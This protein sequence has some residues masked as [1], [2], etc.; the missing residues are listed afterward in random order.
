MAVDDVLELEVVVV[1]VVDFVAVLERCVDVPAVAAAGVWELAVAEPADAARAPT[2]ASVA[3]ALAAPA[4]RLARRA[5]CR[6]RSTPRPTGEGR[7]TGAQAV[8]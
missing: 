5:G 7:P 4:I 6:R 1:V 8:P 3:E 2:M